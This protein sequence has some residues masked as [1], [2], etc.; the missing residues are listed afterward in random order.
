MTS[1]LARAQPRTADVAGADSDDENYCE[2]SFSVFAPVP[3]RCLKAIDT[4]RP[5]KA[6]NPRTVAA[7]HAQVEMGIVEYAVDKW[8]GPSSNQVNLGNNIY[9][10]GLADHLGPIAHWDLQL[11]HTVGSYGLRRRRFGA[12]GQMTVRSKVNLLEGPVQLTLAPL[13][14]VPVMK[15]STTEGGGF[16]F[17]NT[18]LPLGISLDFNV[19]AQSE[20]DAEAKN[21]HV[22]PM[23]IAAF[24]R[25]V[26]GPISVFG[27]LYCDT[28]TRDPSSWNATV[29]FGA[30]ALLG[31][32]WQIDAGAYFGAVGAVPGV[33]PFLGV[34]YRR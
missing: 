16:L 21:R 32:D 13:I 18:E 10:L 31:R 12:S 8:V 24:T 34:S 6:D 15:G 28:T 17:L 33:T 20:T 9:K 23:V 3:Q 11:L 29:D 30:I 27:E 7:G 26:I 19:G 4:D 1:A 5:S 22:T 25:Q 14:V 2:R